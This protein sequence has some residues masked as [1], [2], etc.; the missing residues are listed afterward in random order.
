MSLIGSVWCPILLSKFL[1]PTPCW[2]SL[3]RNW[4][5]V[6]LVLRKCGEIAVG[7]VL[8]NLLS[9]C[10]VVRAGRLLQ[11]GGIR[12]G[13]VCSANVWRHYPADN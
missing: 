13:I 1:L 8:V 10:H 4:L 2:Y 7:F 11:Q 5:V 9:L 6:W 3:E 12:Q